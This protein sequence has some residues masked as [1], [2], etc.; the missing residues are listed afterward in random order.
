MLFLLLFKSIWLVYWHKSFYPS[1][2]FVSWRNK[3]SKTTKFVRGVKSPKEKWLHHTPH[4]LHDGVVNL[5]VGHSLRHG[6]ALSKTHNN[7]ALRVWASWPSRDHHQDIPCDAV[8]NNG[9]CFCRG[10]VKDAAGGHNFSDFSDCD[11]GHGCQNGRKCLCFWWASD[12]GLCN[13]QRRFKWLERCQA[14]SREIGCHECKAKKIIITFM[15]LEYFYF[16]VF[17][18]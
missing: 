15:R 17:V 13:V 14:M 18:I 8:R 2:H 5:R 3:T 10:V 16:H 12:C 11:C 9:K 1:T 4:H 7:N 6:Q